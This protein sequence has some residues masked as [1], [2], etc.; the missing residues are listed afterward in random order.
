VG[1]QYEYQLRLGRS[2]VDWS[3]TIVVN[4]DVYIIVVH[5]STGSTAYARE[6]STPPTLL[7]SMAL[8]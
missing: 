8:L 6:M 1:R 7:W 5:P 4:K 3:Q 2:G